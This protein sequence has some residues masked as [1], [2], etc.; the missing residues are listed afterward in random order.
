MQALATANPSCYNQVLAG[1]GLGCADRLTVTLFA[2]SNWTPLLYDVLQV[3]AR[4]TVTHAPAA[5]D[6]DV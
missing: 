1:A 4:R 5:H 6:R 2:V 3:R